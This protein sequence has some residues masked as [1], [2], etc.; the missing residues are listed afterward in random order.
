LRNYQGELEK[1]QLERWGENAG[2]SSVLGTFSL[3]PQ[4]LHET[5]IKF[6]T[7]NYCGKERQQMP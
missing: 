2:P 7:E 4:C 6:R 5:D 1:E 3:K